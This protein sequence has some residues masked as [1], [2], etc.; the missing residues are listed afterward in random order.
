M[1]LFVG[2]VGAGLVYFVGGAFVKNDAK[3]LQGRNDFGDAARHLPLFV[4]IFDAQKENTSALLGNTAADHGGVQ[5]ADVHETGGAGGK[6]GDTGPLG[7]VTPGIA[8]KKV[9]HRVG[10]DSKEII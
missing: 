9:F 5:A 2:A 8:G 4:G 6:T 7:Q 1:A 3:V 10:D